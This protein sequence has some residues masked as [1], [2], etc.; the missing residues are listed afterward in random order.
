MGSLR[1]DVEMVARALVESRARAQAL[2]KAGHVRLD[3]RVVTKPG[4]AV[5]SQ[6]GIT[7]EAGADHPWASR[8]GLKLVKAIEQ[9]AI[10]PGGKICLDVGAST[11]GFTDVLLTHGASKVY[12]V[13]VGSGQL[14]ARLHN[15]P[16]VVSLENTNARGLTRELIADPVDLIVCDASFI[17][18]ELVL[19]AALALA[20]PTA[21]LVALIKPQFEVG[22]GNVGKNGV[23]SDGVLHEQVCARISAW[24]NSSPGWQV[25]GL[26]D[27]PILGPAGNREFLVYARYQA[28]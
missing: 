15:D 2:I 6:S 25:T 10:Q 20:A 8:G 17:S 9:F 7:L 14:V 28:G 11:G 21:E 1:L 4:E 18:L 26:T 16:R 24:L 22:K 3:G 27:S 12:A 5:T 23:V 13:D 19:P